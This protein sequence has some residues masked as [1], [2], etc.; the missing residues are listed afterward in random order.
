MIISYFAN[1]RVNIIA[2][3]IDLFFL[4]NNYFNKKDTYN[5]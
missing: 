2:I 1:N 5:L 3:S 4:P